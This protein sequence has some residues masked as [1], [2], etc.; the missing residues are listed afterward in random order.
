VV[1]S[2]LIWL[3]P[4]L[5][6]GIL[7][8]LIVRRRA[9]RLW[10]LPLLV[11]GL[12][13]A[14]VLL[15]LRP[16]LRTW[17]VWT[18]KEALHALL[19]L[20]VGFEIVGRMFANLPGAA[21]VARL[22]SWVVI[23]STAI[24]IVLPPYGHPALTTVPRLLAGTAWLYLAA[25]L[26]RIVFLVPL[27]PLHKTVLIAFGPYMMLYA[28]TWGRVGSS[29]EVERVGLI[30]A[31]A[32]VAVLSALLAAAWRADEGPRAAPETVRLLW[33]WRSSRS[34]GRSDSPAR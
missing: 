22:A 12:L 5:E 16:E 29:A 9:G 30:N 14:G 13:V 6:V 27:D 18:L 7:A 15:G 34:R 26:L 10:T 24:V 11:V 21:R 33:P 4:V 2:L 3:G 31:L 19:F 23:L 25:L 17:R 1:R 32:F 8:G 28:L 20:A